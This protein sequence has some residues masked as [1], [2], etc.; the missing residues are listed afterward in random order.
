MMK[1]PSFWMQS[2]I[3]EIILIIALMLFWLASDNSKG[4]INSDGLRQITA[5]AISA[6]G[7]ILII[8]VLGCIA[9]S[10]VNH[11]K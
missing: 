4:V 10:I 9:V 1:N 7:F 3:I 11:R 8:S 2:I 6:L 5:G